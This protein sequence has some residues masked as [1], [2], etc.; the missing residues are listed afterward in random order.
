MDLGFRMEGLGFEVQR[1]RIGDLGY[2]QRF[3]LQGLG[4]KV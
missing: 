2:N 3:E 1:A 4:F